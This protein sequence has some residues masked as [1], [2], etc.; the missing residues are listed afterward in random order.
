M[1]QLSLCTIHTFKC[2][3][4]TELPKDIRLLLDLANGP[5]DD[6]MVALWKDMYDHGLASGKSVSRFDM[7]DHGLATCKSVSTFDMYDHGLTTGKSVSTFDRN[8][9]VVIVMRVGTYI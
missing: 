9:F 6:H 3:I 2:H 8:I 1:N 4:S 7:Y 5:T